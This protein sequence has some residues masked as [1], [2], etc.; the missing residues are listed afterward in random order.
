[1]ISITKYD[2]FHVEKVKPYSKVSNPNSPQEVDHEMQV[3][4]ADLK[5]MINLAEISRQ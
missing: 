3:N 2:Q 4:M 1:M 5:T